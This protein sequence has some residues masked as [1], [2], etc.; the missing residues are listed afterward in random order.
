MHEA[1]PHMGIDYRTLVQLVAER[2]I[3]GVYS[4]GGHIRIDLDEFDEFARVPVED[5]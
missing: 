2:A 4:V 3:P 1:Y 5:L